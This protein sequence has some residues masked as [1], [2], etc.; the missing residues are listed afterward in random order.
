MTETKYILIN[1]R[2]VTD[3]SLFDENSRD[4]CCEPLIALK[5]KCA[6]LGYTLEV[7]KNQDLDAC[8]WIMFWDVTSMGLAALGKE[9]MHS[10]E[11]RIAGNGARDIYQEALEKGLRDRLTLMLCEP[12]SVCAQN[13]DISAHNKFKYIF[14]WDAALA[15]GKRYIRTYLPVTAVYPAVPR[16]PFSEKRMLV[17]ISGNK[18]SLHARELYTER[19]NTIRFFDREL[20]SDFDLYGVGWNT[21]PDTGL[22]NRASNRKL[23]DCF[24]QTYR[25]T[26]R[27]K[28][29][30]LPK[31]KFNICYENIRDERDY[32]SQRI[33]DV[34][35]CGC[36]PI[37]LGAPNIEDYV[38]RDAF[39]DR[40]AFASNEDLAKYIS[41]ISEKEYNTFME[42][43][44]DYLASEKFKL[45]LSPTFVKIIV[46]ALELESTC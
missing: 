17:D 20:A 39:L 12:V 33:F 11:N 26:V 16:I 44:R 40:R 42:A 2:G 8:K 25:G 31:Y 45:F 4:N 13:G 46:D 1:F 37:Y 22:W 28:W 23:G 14:T 38:D 5:K 7:A 24:Y 29:D 27:H 15:D 9:R 21:R 34:L 35:R 41:T 3:Q 18:E 19:R 6:Q 43:G 32:V 10:T 30:I 36:V